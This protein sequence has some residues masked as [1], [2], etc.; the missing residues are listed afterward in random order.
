[1]KHP[2]IVKVLGISEDSN[3]F[4]MEM[5]YCITQ[6]LSK[7]IWHNRTSQYPENIVKAAGTQIMLA[8]RHLHKANI[9]HCN[10]KPSNILVDDYGNIRLCHF[11]KALNINKLNLTE[12]KKE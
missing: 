4:N 8:L 1:M 2:N 6:D 10:L 12:I 5:E 9:L 7:A 11:K 3:Y